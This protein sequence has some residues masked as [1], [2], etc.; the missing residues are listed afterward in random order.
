MRAVRPSSAAGS[1]GASSSPTYT[2]AGSWPDESHLDVPRRQLRADLERSL[3]ESIQQAQARRTADRLQHPL[4]HGTRLLVPD[5]S[6]CREIGFERFDEPCHLHD[7]I[8]TSLWR[9]SSVF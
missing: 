6:H 7:V 4:G 8:M 3:T 2:S 1:G 5:R 9:L